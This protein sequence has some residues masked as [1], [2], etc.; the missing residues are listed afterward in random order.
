MTLAGVKL[1]YGNGF[2]PIKI[3]EWQILGDDCGFL[4]GGCS[5]ATYPG[6]EESHF[7]NS[8]Q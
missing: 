2:R 5:N 1:F 8:A 3:A 6:S 7:F 4:T